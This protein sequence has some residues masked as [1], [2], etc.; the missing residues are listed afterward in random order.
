MAEQYKE[1]LQ[2]HLILFYKRM[3]RLYSPEVIM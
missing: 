2:E 1:V 3:R